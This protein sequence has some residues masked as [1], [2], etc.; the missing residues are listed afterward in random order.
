MQGNENTNPL[1]Q[2]RFLMYKNRGSIIRVA[3]K[4]DCTR[5]WVY[6]VLTGKYESTKV[7]EASYRVLAEMEKEKI[8]VL[9]EKAQKKEQ[10]MK[11]VADLSQQ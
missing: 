5:H 1:E 8:G 2:L 4:L 7:V 10:Y 9:N 11:A 3:K 6:L